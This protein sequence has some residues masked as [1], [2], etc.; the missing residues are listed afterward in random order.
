MEAAPH[1]STLP[2]SQNGSPL[3]LPL[4]SPT[5]SPMS[6]RSLPR[7]F[8]DRARRAALVIYARTGEK[9]AAAKAAGVTLRTINRKLERGGE[10]HDPEFAEAMDESLERWLGS[11][12]QAAYSRAV[13]GWVE[14]KGTRGGTVLDVRKYDGALLMFL[15]KGNDPRFRDRVQVDSNVRGKVEHGGRIE[16]AE[17]GAADREAVRGLLMRAR[18]RA[19]P[20]E[21]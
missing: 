11:M 5:M 4:G 2:P 19:L 14:R 21:N 9:L 3:T 13:Q 18:E 12:R 1:A 10:H 15:L 17:L 8:T 16:I 7:K 20:S 6:Y